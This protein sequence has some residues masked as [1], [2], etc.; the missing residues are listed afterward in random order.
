V[1]IE[2][3][4]LHISCEHAGR[5]EEKVSRYTGR[6]GTRGLTLFRLVSLLVSHIHKVSLTQEFI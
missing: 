6:P 4:N 1:Y 5:P 2:P 3:A